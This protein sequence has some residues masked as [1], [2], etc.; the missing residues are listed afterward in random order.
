MTL[1][2]ILNQFTSPCLFL[3]IW[4]CPPPPNECVRWE[5]EISHWF[6]IPQWNFG[7]TEDWAWNL[8]HT[9]QQPYHWATF[10]VQLNES[11][12]STLYKGKWSPTCFRKRNS[13]QTWALK[14]LWHFRRFQESGKLRP[15]LEGAVWVDMGLWHESLLPS[16]Q[17]KF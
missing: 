14:V 6:V 15:Y 17:P 4:K 5:I 9:R 12:I 8:V 2:L 1:Y 16:L 7:D 10:S 13:E 3:P 11:W